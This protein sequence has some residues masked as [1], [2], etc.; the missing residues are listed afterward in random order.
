MVKVTHL[1]ISLAGI[2]TNYSYNV[3]VHY[4][5]PTN[6]N[7][8]H[9]A[10]GKQK[11]HSYGSR[12]RRYEGR[13]I[14]VWKNEDFLK[15]YKM[16]KRER[17]LKNVMDAYNLDIEEMAQLLQILLIIERCPYPPRMLEAIGAYVQEFKALRG[18]RAPRGNHK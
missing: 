7:L 13:K 14:P 9:S 3:I 4:S 2:R 17:I 10:N 12:D 8:N 6:F 16:E 15:R 5:R 11:S 1:E 18:N